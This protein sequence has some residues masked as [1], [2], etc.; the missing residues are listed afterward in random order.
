M[1]RKRHYFSGQLAQ[2]ICEPRSRGLLGLPTE[3]ERNRRILERAIDKLPLLLDH[4]G[5]DRRD[6]HCWIDLSFRLAVDFVPGMRVGES[7]SRPGRRRIWKAGEGID[8]LRAVEE[9]MSSRPCSIKQA[10]ETL[11]ST[12][13]RWSTYTPANLVTRHRE[14]RREQVHRRR[15]VA[16]MLSSDGSVSLARLKEAYDAG[17]TGLFGLGAAAAGATPQTDENPKD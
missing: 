3:E 7:N 11:I 13:K 2:P 8:L 16:E 5:I 15:A 17:L 10:I 14:A 4:Y 1:A 12:E 6:E 9:Q